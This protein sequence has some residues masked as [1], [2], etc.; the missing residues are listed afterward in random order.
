MAQLKDGEMKPNRIDQHVGAQRARWRERRALEQKNLAERTGISRS[1]IC[2]YESGESRAYGITLW[3]ISKALDIP[4]SYFFNGLPV[5]AD[6][7]QDNEVK[8]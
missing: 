7:V 2:R 1:I 6:T 4:I 3:R 8:E 5:E